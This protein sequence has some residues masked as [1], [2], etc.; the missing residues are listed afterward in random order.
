[1]MK[2]RIAYLWVGPFVILFL[3]FWAWPI[4]FSFTLS[5]YRW[6]LIGD[7]TFIGFQNFK[8]LIF[9]QYYWTA[10]WNTLYYWIIIVPPRTFFALVLAAILNSPYVHGKKFFRAIIVLPFMTA[11]IFVAL[12]FKVLLADGGGWIN[13]ALERFFNLPSIPWLTSESWSKISVSL[14]EHWNQLG[15][16]MLILLG[17]LQK[18]PRDLYEASTIDGATAIRSFISITVPLM[19]PIVAFVTITS[20]I[21][22]FA[23]L[24]APLLLT[25]GGPGVSST[26]LTLRLWRNAFDYFKLGYA[27]AY[28]VIIFLLVMSL[29]IIQLRV[30][31]SR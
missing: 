5:L 15:F 28:A 4:I 7:P 19:L 25:E 20:T 16:F 27:S 10:L 18:I 30:L 26:T 1:M 6:E 14:V 22:I 29:S 31:K 24:E 11:P 3:L 21:E 9:D 13:V 8:N 23:L 2:Y 12:L 17:G